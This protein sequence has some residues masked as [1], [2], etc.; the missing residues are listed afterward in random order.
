[1][2]EELQEMIRVARRRLRMASGIPPTADEQAEERRLAQILEMDLFISRKFGVRLSIAAH[3][4]TVYRGTDAAAEMTVDGH[5]FELRKDGAVFVL[6]AM[7]DG[8][9]V[10]LTRTDSTDPEFANRV[11]VVIADALA[12]PG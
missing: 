6:F 3:M 4:K 8:D 1:M 12:K 5:I 9:D 2:T 7:K 10:E 11:L